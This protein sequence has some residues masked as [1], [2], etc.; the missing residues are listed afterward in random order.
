M[1]FL[2]FLK[3]KAQFADDFYQYIIESE[4]IAGNW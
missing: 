1:L 3:V 4:A 2:L